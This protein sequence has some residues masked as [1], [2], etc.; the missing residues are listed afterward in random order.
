MSRYDEAHELP[1]LRCF[2][3]R[4]PLVLH[5]PS[6]S[7][8]RIAFLLRRPG[9]KWHFE[10]LGF[11]PCALEM[12]WLLSGSSPFFSQVFVF[13]YTWYWQYEYSTSMNFLSLL[14]RCIGI[15]HKT[16]TSVTP[17][18]PLAIGTRRLQVGRSASSSGSHCIFKW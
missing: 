8:S 14:L 16:T 6:T 3:H 12:P 18:P 10:F 4:G 11:G 5:P 17:A 7:C 2:Y 13:E 15:S 9:C 1:W